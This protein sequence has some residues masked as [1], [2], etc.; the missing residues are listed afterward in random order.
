MLAYTSPEWGRDSPFAPVIP[1]RGMRPSV[2]VSPS[3]ETW[4]ASRD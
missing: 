4:L 1:V 3:M 2:Q